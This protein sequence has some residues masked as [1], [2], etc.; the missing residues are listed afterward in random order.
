[1]R[2]RVSLKVSFG[3]GPIITHVTLVRSFPSVGPHVLHQ[4]GVTGTDL[5]TYRTHCL[6]FIIGVHVDAAKGLQFFRG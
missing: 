1:M 6:D 4:G 5:L 2:N 3:R